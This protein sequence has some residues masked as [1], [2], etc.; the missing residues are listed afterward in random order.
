MKSIITLKCRNFNCLLTFKISSLNLEFLMKIQVVTA[1]TVVVGNIWCAKNHS[2]P[3]LKDG[4]TVFSFTQTAT[5][6]SRA[7]IAYFALILL[8][9]TPYNQN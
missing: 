2:L 9:K 5:S 6:L 4:R 8:K 7:A 1:H 3:V